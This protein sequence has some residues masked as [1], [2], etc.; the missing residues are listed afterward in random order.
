[1]MVEYFIVSMYHCIHLPKK[2]HTRVSKTKNLVGNRVV[3]N[4][5][6]DQSGID[7]SANTIRLEL[8]ETPFNVAGTRSA[9]TLGYEW[10]AVV[11]K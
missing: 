1:M 8:N 5:I 11:A 4:G 3:V 10:G 9:V 2:H 7:R 6:E